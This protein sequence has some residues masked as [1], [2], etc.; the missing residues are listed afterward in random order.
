MMVEKLLKFFIT[1][2]N[3]ELFKTI[4]LK[5]KIIRLRFS[6]VNAINTYFRL[7]SIFLNSVGTGGGVKR[8]RP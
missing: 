8:I 4:I 2:V 3:A 6:L 5:N 7:K 1:K